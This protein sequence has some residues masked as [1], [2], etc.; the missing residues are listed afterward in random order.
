M[1]K[2]ISRRELIKIMGLSAYAASRDPFKIALATTM[3]GIVERAVAGESTGPQP[4]NYIMLQLYGAPPR[5]TWEPIAPFDNQNLIL[6]NNSVT[7]KYNVGGSGSF[8]S[9]NYQAVNIKGISMPWMWQFDLPTSSGSVPMSELMNN[10]LMI[11]GVNVII[12][13]HTGAA[14]KQFR[15]TGI[16]N[17]MTSLSGDVSSC[18]IPFI[19]MNTTANPYTSKK[20]KTGVSS[21]NMSGNCLQNLLEPFIVNAPSLQNNLNSMETLIN[22]AIDRIE[23]FLTGI[24]S[25]FSLSKKAQT[26]ALT[27]IKK[28][29][30]SLIHD[31]YPLKEKYLSLLQIATK[32]VPTGDPRT[33]LNSINTHSI[34]IDNTDLRVTLD[35]SQ[36]YNGDYFG[37]YLMAEQF[38]VIEFAIKN[39]LTTSIAAG[40]SSFNN[41]GFDEHSTAP[42]ISVLVNTLWNRGMATC[43]YELIDQ[44]RAAGMWENTVINITSEFGRSPRG[45]GIGSDHAP[46][47]T[48][49]T[50]LS[51][52]LAGN[53]IIGNTKIDSGWNFYPGSWG[54]FANNP[55]FGILGQGHIAST[56]AS[57]LKVESPVTSSP[58]L[59]TEINGRMKAR[60]GP[61]KLV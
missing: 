3:S 19:G 57:L 13:E 6:P 49:I 28:D 52:C 60:L 33:R 12:P 36:Y 47:A 30:A 42:M 10:M 23:S 4:R 43:V 17:T 51:G 9:T 32:A 56:I 11:R 31:F 53:E 46:E 16:P 58:S 39:R 15:P 26:D 5:W 61:S 59:V 40:L 34:M 27:L 2:K 38:A 29:F 8:E 55:T 18:P 14:D 24:H 54:S 22:Q 25:G 37:I 41:F 1:T 20:N 7:T 45:D 48:S 50:L 44:L 21:L 35:A